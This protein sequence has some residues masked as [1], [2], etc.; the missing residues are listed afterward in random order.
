[1]K[2]SSIQLPYFWATDSASQKYPVKADCVHIKT[3]IQLTHNLQ[4]C[5]TAIRIFGCF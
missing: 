3:M 2:L 4:L 5:P 1:M